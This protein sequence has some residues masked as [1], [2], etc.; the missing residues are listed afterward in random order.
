MPEGGAE[1]P[2]CRNDYLSAIRHLTTVEQDNVLQ[3]ISYSDLSVEEIG[4]I[5][6][7]LL[8]I[9]RASAPRR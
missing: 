6:E 4:S 7:S 9:T 3:R 8:D 1:A 2:R 5:Y